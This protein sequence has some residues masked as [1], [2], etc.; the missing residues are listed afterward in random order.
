MPTVVDLAHL[1]SSGFTIQGASAYDHA[2]WSVSDAGDVNGDG[3]D[4]V[5]VGT[6]FNGAYV[7]FG[8]SGGFGTIDLDT[9][10]PGVGFE[11][12]GGDNIDIGEQVSA[13][14]DV[15]GD[16]FDDLIVGGSAY[17]GGGFYDYYGGGAASAYVIFG[18]GSA[19]GTI[20]VS[21]LAPSAGF[22]L[23]SEFHYY[24]YTALRV[25]SAGDI[26][27]DGFD[28]II[29]SSHYD[30]SF[31]G[32]AYVIFGKASGFGPIDLTALSPGVGFEIAGGAD[33]DQ[34][35]ISVSGAGDVNGDGFDDVII[36]ANQGDAGGPNAGQAYVIFGKASGFGTINLASL[37]A[38]AGFLIQ[39]DEGLDQAGFSVSSAGD[40]NGDGYDDLIVGA[41]FNDDGAGSAGAAYV[42]FGKASGFGTVDLSNVSTGGFA[43][44][45]DSS[46][47]YAGWSVSSAG[48]VNGDGFDDVI[49]GAQWAS[50]AYVVYGKPAG[51]GTVDLGNLQPADGF[52]IQG[53]AGDNAG[54]S[55]SAAGDINGDGFDDVLVGA[56]NVA[57]YGYNS[58]A[59]EAYVVFGSGALEDNREVANDFNGDGR[60][61]IFWRHANG[62]IGN[63]LA[64]PNGSYAINDS[65]LAAVPTYWQVAGT[66]DFNGD[67]RD[68]V[69]WRGAGGEVGNWLASPG[70]TFAFNPA[71][72]VTTVSTSWQ[73]VGVGDF[74]G[75]TR[76]DILWRHSD[77]RIGTWL[78][79]T[80][81]SY[82]IN[83]P[84]ITAVPNY[85]EVAGIGDFNDDGRDDI[86][87]RGANGEVG[88][89]LA[90]LNG[91]FAFNAAAGI[92]GAPN[93]WQIVGVGDFNG[94]NRDD[95]LWRHTDGRIGNWLANEDGRH[96]AN[97][98]SIAAVSNYWQL[99][100]I[101]AYNDDNR[102][103]ILWRGDGGEVGNW[104]AG[105]TGIFAFNA[106]AGVTPI[107]A[108]WQVV[109]DPSLV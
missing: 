42:I 76:D 105:P 99:A 79:N 45:G 12:Q 74:N 57:F 94:D 40:V 41:P 33:F 24:S 98:A 86:L 5:I 19:F 56:P 21:Q 100:A 15:N 77:G 39:G 32:A 59:G 18:K 46:N 101:G 93:A 70:A 11:I 22:A 106:A 80:N 6:Q 107:A 83:D 108:S 52:I 89:W 91:T 37:S 30:N 109:P 3:F 81:G 84:S 7:I 26:N 38:A 28:D 53:G 102:D 9:I 48:D 90:G 54:W 50:K 55:V 1:G 36:G 85:W 96:S 104:L 69:L 44:L 65:S 88:N 49:V 78:A 75:D 25:A 97:D 63:W 73:I 2:G 64:N 31:D 71:A 60:S 8:K 103:D 92:S 43:I 95:I 4:D 13:A 16:G 35:G 10:T 62:T 29:L 17:Y 61:D 27:G 82:A 87:W 34:A 58:A 66:G 72:G 47:D 51:F 68:D 67:G 23:Q 20:D 14:G